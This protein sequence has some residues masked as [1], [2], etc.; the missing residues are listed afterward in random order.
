MRE[1]VLAAIKKH[2]PCTVGDIAKEVGGVSGA[3][4]VPILKELREEC[5][6]ELEQGKY[7]IDCITTEPTEAEDIDSEK[8]MRNE[9]IRSALQSLEQ[10][11]SK[12]IEPPTEFDLKH[13]VL[14]RLSA[15]LHDDISAVLESIANDLAEYQKLGEV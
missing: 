3:E 2:Q 11:L 6:A 12:K 14:N 1:A 8:I 4:L 10:Q 13:A 15:L 7:Y 5:I 9:K